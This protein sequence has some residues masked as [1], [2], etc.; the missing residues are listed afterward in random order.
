MLYD[1]KITE[2]KNVTTEFDSPKDAYKYAQSMS[3]IS[4]RQNY[5]DYPKSSQEFFGSHGEWLTLDEFESA[6]YEY[7]HK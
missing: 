1:F 3:A 7:N 2:Q 6:V 5:T 4:I